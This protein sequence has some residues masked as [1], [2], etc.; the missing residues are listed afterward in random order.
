MCSWYKSSFLELRASP[1]PVDKE[2][3]SQFA[4]II[5]VIYSRHSHTL[6]TMAKGA[7][8]I[9]KSLNKDVL[10]FADFGEIQEILDNFYR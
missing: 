9:R 1:R 5:D 8:E 7:H 10:S 4:K 6:I 2:K 3:E